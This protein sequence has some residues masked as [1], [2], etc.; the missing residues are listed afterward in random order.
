[1]DAKTHSIPVTAGPRES[2]HAL[3]EDDAIEQVR[4]GYRQL[5]DLSPATERSLRAVLEHVLGHPGSLVRAQLAY[6][7]Q[8]AHAVAEPLALAVAVAIEYFHTA[9]LVFDDMPAMDHAT[10]RRG[11][12]CAHVAHGEAAATLGGL[13]LINRGYA[14]LWEVIAA[15][16]EE[17]RRDASR[18]VTSC[19]GVQG[20]L[21]GQ[22]LDLN[23]ASSARRERDVLDV[24][25]G[26]TVP[27]IRLSLLLPALVSGVSVAVRRELDHLATLWGFAYQIMDDF[28]DCLMTPEETGKTAA[29]DAL[30][31]RPNLPG[32]IGWPAA[33][34]R[35]DTMMGEA[36]ALVR[37][38]AGRHAAWSV[39]AR[40]Q[41]V[42]DR[43]QARIHDRLVAL[44]AA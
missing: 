38:L 40:L 20:I 44:A 13:A 8:R 18:L 31:T 23:F 43:E 34:Q 17:P 41:A 36:R 39:L 32:A 1:M 7:I 35:L 21:N 19:L 29:R 25:A 22:S 12:P 42:L 10:E 5:M 24:A 27:L 3:L 14:L 26:K 37:D 28:K 2:A 4:A 15:L 30:L 16:P 33:R 9:S 6:H 11:I